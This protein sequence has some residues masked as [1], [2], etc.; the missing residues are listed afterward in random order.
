PIMDIMQTLPT[1]VYLIPVML[2]FGLG[3]TSAITATVIYALPPMTRMTN[4][5]LRQV[6]ASAIEAANSLGSTPRQRLF[7]VSLPLARPSIM[8]GLNQTIMM[9]LS[10]AIF[11]ALIGSAG[12]GRDVWYAMRRLNIG[13]ALEAGLAV[14]LLAIILDRVSSA[15]RPAYARASQRQVGEKPGLD[16]WMRQPR[17]MAAVFGMGTVVTLLIHAFLFDL[18]EYPA[19]LQFHFA[20]SANVAVRWINVHL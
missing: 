5:G 13:T 7:K 12:L 8:M 3:A 18:S 20:E 6:P 14:V 1:F 2:L 17:V 4:L 16:A 15:I 19:A 10:M 9:A 11:V